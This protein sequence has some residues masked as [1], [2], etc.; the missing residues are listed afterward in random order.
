MPSIPQYLTQ[1][2]LRERSGFPS[3]TPQAPGVQEPELPLGASQALGGAVARLGQ[4]IG[5]AGDLLT[6]A[7]DLQER[8][9][10]AD[11]LI[12]SK[13]REQDI[14]PR[15]GE[16]FNEQS[17]NPDY[18]SLAKR[19][20]AEGKRIIEEG[21]VGLDARTK[22]LYQL[23]V[24]EKLATWHQRALADEAKR[25]DEAGAYVFQ[26][27]LNQGRQAILDAQNPLERI[28][29]Q[30]DMEDTAKRMVDAGLARGTAAAELVRQTLESAE[31]YET[32]RAIRVDPKAMVPHLEALAANKPGVAGL[33]VPPKYKIHELL[34]DAQNELREYRETM[35]RGDIQADKDVRQAQDKAETALTNEL[36]GLATAE[37]PDPQAIAT[38]QRKIMSAGSEGT[39]SKEGHQRLLGL[40]ATLLRGVERVKPLQDDPATVHRF[41]R[42]IM[43]PN[44]QYPWP[45][46]DEVDDAVKS[47]KLKPETAGQIIKDRV[48]LLDEAHPS[49]IFE[50]QQGKTR[51]REAITQTIGPLD[52]SGDPGAKTPQMQ[53]YLEADALYDAMIRQAQD[54]AQTPQ[55]KIEIARQV[56]GPLAQQIVQHYAPHFVAQAQKDLPKLLYGVEDVFVKEGLTAA[57]NAVEAQ[58]AT[59]PP[60]VY[61]ASKENLLRRKQLNWRGGEPL[62]IPPDDPTSKV[63][64]WF[65]DLFGGGTGTP[66][67]Q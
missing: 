20:Q 8:V 1:Q 18:A 65:Q 3:M 12:A 15:L 56:A 17:Q 33:P 66:K 64:K 47:G 29:A 4:D 44:P 40:S 7:E 16:M 6:R 22:Q 62:P 46:L 57:A 60:E 2:G 51:L 24:N 38:V 23:N 26:T 31:E 37:N 21:S 11:R 30:A 35:H 36:Y 58:R 27:E 67:I 14:A 42:G 50:A 32:R 41:N 39:V 13:Q 19:V 61:E 49:K 52:I 9:A 59:M 63:R 25:R 34:D 5:G 48:R 53:R 43:T 54:Q 28:K 55:Q 10:R 45:T